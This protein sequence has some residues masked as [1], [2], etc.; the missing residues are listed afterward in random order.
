MN[1][2]ADTRLARLRARE[3]A[4]IAMLESIEAKLARLTNARGERRSALFNIRAE[5]EALLRE[6]GHPSMH[7]SRSRPIPAVPSERNNHTTIK[8]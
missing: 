6:V 5:I 7:P 2:T 4:T 8:E 1:D 3:A